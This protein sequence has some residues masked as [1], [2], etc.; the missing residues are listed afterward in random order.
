M[1]DKLYW[2]KK[3]KKEVVLPSDYF[4]C[5]RCLCNEFDYSNNQSFVKEYET[6]KYKQTCKKCGEI[7]YTDKKYLIDELNRFELMSIKKE[8]EQKQHEKKEKEKKLKDDLEKAKK[9]TTKNENRS[10]E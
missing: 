7:F 4:V 9:L 10:H 6:K 3:T 5:N 8:R 2:D 1:P